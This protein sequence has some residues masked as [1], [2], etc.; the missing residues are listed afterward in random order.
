MFILILLYKVVQN[1]CTYKN[2]TKVNSA[3]NAYAYFIYILQEEC[4]HTTELSKNGALWQLGSTEVTDVT[5]EGQ[6]AP[7]WNA[8]V[9]AGTGLG[10]FKFMQTFQSSHLF[11]FD[12]AIFLLTCGLKPLFYKVEKENTDKIMQ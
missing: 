12:Y 1:Y 8:I 7:R 10:P 2:G 11:T 3:V 9:K 5:P 4:S 6:I